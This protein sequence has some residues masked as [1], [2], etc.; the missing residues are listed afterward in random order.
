[1]ALSMSRPWKHPKTG[2]YWLRKVVPDELRATVGKRELKFSLK[3]K[4]AAEAKQRHAAELAKIEAQLAN[5][6]QPPKR[7]S[8]TELQHRFRLCV[9]A[10]LG[11][12]R[13]P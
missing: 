9:R 1:M 13:P 2:I 10:L 7:I 12:E 8:L 11:G 5:L 6:R 3:T 4:D